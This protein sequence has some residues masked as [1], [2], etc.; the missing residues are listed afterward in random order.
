[1]KIND[2]TVGTIT[3]LLGIIVVA[4]ILC[5]ALRNSILTPLKEIRES[6]EYFNDSVSGY[7]NEKSEDISD[8]N[9][10]KID[11]DGHSYIYI[12]K[13]FS[14]KDWGGYND[15]YSVSLAHDENCKCKTTK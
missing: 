8:L 6:K 12:E 3:I 1:M 4:T 13:R 15:E 9:I 2:E 10:K 14:P 11:I 7:Q 5:C